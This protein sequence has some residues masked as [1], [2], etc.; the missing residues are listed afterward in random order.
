MRPLTTFKLVLKRIT[1]DWKLLLSIFVGI[2]VAASLLAGAP[3]YIRTLERQGINT[4][5]ER[6]DQSYLNI[7]T[8]APYITLSK[9]ELNSTEAAIGGSIDDQIS[10]IYRGRERYLKTPTYLVGTPQNPLTPEQG[11]RVSRGYMQN[12]SNLND[13]VTWL[14]GRM[15]SD[16]V[17]QTPGGPRLEAVIGDVTANVFDIWTGDV[18]TFTPSLNDPIRVTMEIVGVLEPADPGE[19]FWQQNANLFLQPQ[20]LQE[21]P[22]VGIEIDPDEPPLALFISHEALVEGVGKAYPGSFVSSTW[23]ISVDK[24]GLTLWSKEF[25]RERLARLEADVT[26]A[27]R[28]AAVLT[29]IDKLLNDFERRSFFSGVPLLLLLVVMVMTVLYY[30]SMMVSYLVQSREDDVALLRSRGVTTWQLGRLYALEGLALVV[31]ASVIAP[32]LALGAV[33]Y[34]GKLG[35]FR[36]ITF[37]ETLPVAFHWMPFAVAAGTGLLGLA[38]FVLPAVIGARSGLVAHKTRSSRPPS[39]PFFQKFYLDVGLLVIGGLI[40]W[41][42][43]SRGQLISGGLFSDVQVNEAL[44]FAP[45]LLLTV[46]ALLF[47]RFFPLVVRFISG[48]SSALIHLMAVASFVTLTLFIMIR[49]LRVDTSVEWIWEVA[50]IGVVAALYYGTNRTESVWNRTAGLVTQGGLIALLIYADMPAR[51]DILFLPTLAFALIVP[52][53]VLFIVLRRLNRFYPVW[54]SM[55]IWH[56]ARN[57]LQYSWLVLLLVMVTGLGILATTVG[58]TLDRSYEERILYE[59]GSDLRM[60]GVPTYFAIGNDEIKERFLAIPGVTSISLGLRGGGIVGTT[61]SGNNFSVLAIEAEEFPYIAWYRDDFSERSL[62]GVMRALHSGVHAEPIDI[63]EGAQ[64]LKVWA[65]AEDYYPNMFLWMVVQDRRGVL[66]T[67][68]L[69]PMPEPGWTLMET[70]LPQHLEWPLSLVSVQIYEPVFGP[71][72]T[73]GEMYLDD[74]HVEFG[75][76][77]EPQILDDFEG[78]SKWTTLATSLISSDVVGVTDDAH[79]TGRR[80]GV[81]KFGKDTDQGIRGFYRS[82]SG[83]PVPVVSSASF[84]KATGAGVGDAII[85][86]LMGRLVPIRIMDTVDYFPTM[87]PS[88]NGFLLMDL[89]NALRH[90]NI[91]SPVTTVR[92]NEIFISEVPGAEEEV[93]KIAL[94]LAPSRNQVHDR[95]SLVESVRLDPLITA[96]W[97]AMALLA[98]GVILFAAT[99]GYVTYLISFS[100]QS[101]SEMGFLQ[102]LGL[103]K[104]Q[105]GWLLSAEHLVI[106]ALGLLIG[107]AA[108]FAMSNIMVASVAV[109]EQGTPVLPPFVLTTD[110]SIMGPVYAALVLIFT[111]SLYWLVRTSS[112]VDLYEI[113]RIEGE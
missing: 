74:I 4:A 2:T 27:M 30:V 108:G 31:T 105:M 72:G 45:V 5:I 42:L 28:G 95:A 52:F 6:A 57:P 29:G 7:F 3:V 50:M 102:A 49:E 41:E 40:F 100:A 88:R 82:P 21:L 1:D 68:T 19:E 85:V 9:D 90:L 111:G 103:S 15:A 70:T 39:V 12:M 44:L 43:Q 109:T 73:V 58:G 59:V 13:H 10:D 46:V 16:E 32:F 84:S 18:V 83:G 93:H 20:P 54:A 63:P 92:P 36:D 71:S 23:Y 61:Y 25:A 8:Y 81:F 104:R 65:D 99:L 48:D 47:I 64:K 56:M 17:V 87:D 35:Y 37:G 53:Q 101:R 86:N 97:K 79:V 94:S 96:G 24:K 38:M 78:S 98:I 14:S 91:L 33:A 62:T 76:G 113:S 22:D 107:T 112:N 89:D 67:L 110:W 66:D 60:T 34:A 75:N 106:A 26:S 51:D 77:R 80:A 11:T 69:G 55:A